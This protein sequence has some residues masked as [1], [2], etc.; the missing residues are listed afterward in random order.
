[1]STRYPLLLANTK[2]GY[3]YDIG[4]LPEGNYLVRVQLPKDVTCSQCIFQVTKF[5]QVSRFT[6]YFQ[7]C[8]LRHILLVK[9]SFVSFKKNLYTFRFYEERLHFLWPSVLPTPTWSRI[10]L[11]FSAYLHYSGLTQQETVGA[12]VPTVLERWAAARKRRSELVLTSPSHLW[13]R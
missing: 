10:L 4:D 13:Y 8:K 11:S 9:N 12:P 5:Y 2:D 1:M 3:Y 6:P 7:T